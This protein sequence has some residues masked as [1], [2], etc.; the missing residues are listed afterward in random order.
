MNQ[1]LMG[2]EQAS[3][4]ENC[5]TLIGQFCLETASLVLVFSE[6]SCVAVAQVDAEEVGSQEHDDDEGTFEAENALGER[7]QVNVEYAMEVC[8]GVDGTHEQLQDEGEGPR[9]PYTGVEMQKGM[10]R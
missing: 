3:Y 6:R 1:V 5:V 8:D 4:L 2:R 9:V 7:L 10:R